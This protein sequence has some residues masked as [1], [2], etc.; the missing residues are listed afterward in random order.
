MRFRWTIA[1][2]VVALLVGGA[3]VVMAML[4]SSL[5]PARAALRYPWGL[6]STEAETM[7][8]CVE[9]HEPDKFHT[10]DSCHDDHGSAEMASVPFDDLIL[11][12]GD[13]P[14]P[15]YIP[16]NDI[17][18]YRDQPGTHVTLL[19]FL[20]VHGVSEF[21][22]VTLASRD[23]GF[24]TLEAP[25]LT[26]EAL[27]MPHVDGLRFAAENLHV[28]TW[29]KGVWHIIV[30]GREKPLTIDGQ[31]TSMGRLMLGPTRSVTLEQADVMLH[32]KTD[33][34]VRMGKTASRVEGAGLSDIVGDPGFDALL[35][36]DEAGQEHMLTAAEAKGA[37]LAQM[38][39]QIVL[40]LPARGR[41]QWITGVVELVSEE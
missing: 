38:G 14:E 41:A 15:G 40:V 10:C 22:S 18:P 35:I 26:S 39:R 3:A 6:L 31:R 8:D 17:L 33:G 37:M 21:D 20:S 24:V 32:S 7:N 2:V 19:G 1:A 30:V 34:Q 5:A 29:L 4:S 23:E 36:R 16:L 27:L 12:A 13:V 11:L 28:S 25:N 9:C